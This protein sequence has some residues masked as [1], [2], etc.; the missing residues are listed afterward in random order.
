MIRGY[1]GKD[2][3]ANNEIM[4]CVKHFALYG[5][6]EA[7]RDYNTVDMSRN[8]MF[9]EYFPPYKAAVEAG[10]GSAMT[11]FNEIDGVPATANHWL[12]TDVLRNQWG[13]DGFVVTDYTAI[14][15]MIDHGIGDLQEVSARALTAGT[16]MDMVADGFIGTLEKSLKEGKVTEAD[17]D[18]ACRCILEAKYKLGLFAN[19]Y[20]YCDVKRAE[21]KCSLPN[22]VPSPARLPQ[23][24]SYC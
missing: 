2:M 15:E 4:A 20:K 3:S 7:G 16:D 13:F 5:A 10:V 6:G 9:N 8:R 12:L 14:S 23:R 11:S 24:H 1:Q 18:K 21:K 22:T 17:I 19:P